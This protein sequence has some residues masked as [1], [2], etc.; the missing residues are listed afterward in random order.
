METIILG[1]AG[2][3]LPDDAKKAGYKQFRPYDWKQIFFSPSNNFTGT[4]QE[5]VNAGLAYQY[6]TGQHGRRCALRGN[7]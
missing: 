3:Q 4:E 5:F 2:I 7:T 1:S 6:A